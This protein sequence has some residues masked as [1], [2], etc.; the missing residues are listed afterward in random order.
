M[1]LNKV[2]DNQ[3]TLNQVFFQKIHKNIFYEYYDS[4]IPF[5]FSY[6]SYFLFCDIFLS[7]NYLEISHNDI[8]DKCYI[9]P[10]ESKINK[11]KLLKLSSLTQFTKQLILFNFNF[12]VG[13]TFNKRKYTYLSFRKVD[14]FLD[15]IINNNIKKYKKYE[16]KILS[17]IGKYLD[18]KKI[19]KENKNKILKNLMSSFRK[20]D[21]F[22]IYSFEAK[23]FENII[24]NYTKEKMK[25]QTQKV[26]MRVFQLTEDAKNNIQKIKKTKNNDCTIL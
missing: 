22:E 12:P 1:N 25:I 16:I 3:D 19:T 15:E 26:E 20:N 8:F 14:F 7:N 24:D 2:V 6:E 10:F 13:Y 5:A 17:Y 11:E 18:N 4:F 9:L 21:K 23:E